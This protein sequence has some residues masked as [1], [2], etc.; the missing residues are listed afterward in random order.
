[1]TGAG[2]KRAKRE[3]KK[4]TPT[5]LSKAAAPT[6]RAKSHSLREA[7]IALKRR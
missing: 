7:T 5:P 6:T 1:M 3:L 2:E 4:K